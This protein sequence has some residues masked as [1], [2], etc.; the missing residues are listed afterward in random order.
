[1]N[2]KEVDR[3][4]AKDILAKIEKGKVN[5]MLDEFLKANIQ[6]AEV[7]KEDIE[8][9]TSVRSA[10]QVIRPAV[11]RYNKKNKAFL[12]VCQSKEHIYLINRS[13]SE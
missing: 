10:I 3:S 13:I 11:T 7:C 12:S 9:Y 4:I 5:K 6:V 1:M 2:F 8:K